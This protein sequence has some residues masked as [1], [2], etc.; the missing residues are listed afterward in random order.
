[1]QDNRFRAHR[2]A[3]SLRSDHFWYLFRAYSYFVSVRISAILCA[4]VLFIDIAVLF[5]R[6]IA[7]VQ[8]E[9]VTQTRLFWQRLF[10]VAH[11]KAP[12]YMEERR[13]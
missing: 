11:G 2:S 5:L 4:F 9:G 10:L 6:A 13:S 8:A 12:S 3:A 7:G 1:M